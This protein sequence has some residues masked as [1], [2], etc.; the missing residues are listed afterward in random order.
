MDTIQRLQKENR[1]L[2]E[3]QLEDIKEAEES[4]QLITALQQRLQAERTHQVHHPRP[5]VGGSIFAKDTMHDWKLSPA[6]KDSDISHMESSYVQAQFTERVKIS[7]QK[8]DD[9]SKLPARTAHEEGTLEGVLSDLDQLEMSYTQI[10]LPDVDKRSRKYFDK[11][12]YNYMDTSSLEHG[13]GNFRIVD[14]V[15]CNNFKKGKN[16]RTL[17]YKTY[18]T[19][20]YDSLPSRESEFEY[21]PCREV[22]DHPT[23]RWKDVENRANH[24]DVTDESWVHSTAPGS[25]AIS[26]RIDVLDQPPPSTIRKARSDSEAHGYLAALYRELDAFK[27]RG[28]TEVP[29]NLDIHNIP[30]ELILQ[31]MPLFS[32]KYEGMNFSKF[33][34]RMV[35]LGN[36]WKNEHGIDTFSDMV[37]MDTLKILLAMAASADWEIYKVDVVEAFLTTQVNKRYPSHISKHKHEDMSYF[38]RRPPGLTDEEMPYIMKPTCYIYGHPLAMIFFNM[39]VKQMFIDGLEFSQSHYDKRVYYKH[40][41]R[42][43]VIIAHAVDDFTIFASS[44]TLKTWIISEISTRYPDVTIQHELETVLGIEVSRD[45]NNRTITLKQEGSIHNC[46]NYHLPDWKTIPLDELPNSVLSPIP[47]HMSKEDTLLNATVLPD[48]DRALYQRK[49]G[50]LVWITHTLPELMFAYKLKARKNTKPTA[51]DMKHVDYIIRYLAKI[52]RNDDVKLVL[53]GKQGI[54]MVGTVDTSYAPDGE[55]YKSIT[56][57]TIHMA[58]NTGSILTMCSR[59]TICA[60]SSMSAEGIGCHLLVR[61]IIPIRYFFKELGFPQQHPTMIYMDN[62]PFINSIVGDKGASVKSK[63]IMIRLSLI[64]E[65]YDN[66]DIDFHYMKTSDIPSDMLSKLVPASTHQHLRKFINGQMPLV[67]DSTISYSKE[68]KENTTDHF[69]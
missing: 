25:K 2:R 35:V 23:T 41:E 19:D 61:R 15:R 34:C 28:A 10:R 3:A 14:I 43:T 27:R 33:K 54:T 21:I 66:G 51:L 36:K 8:K 13:G 40:D 50:E 58:S 64:N 69:L 4:T 53:G 22:Y 26:N 46:L 60:D 44:H 32:K 30:P 29:E 18:D 38:T 17:F 16:S 7:R 55:N 9:R 12:G 63:H 31:L 49:I 48:K 5:S 37:H 45:R 67:T 59:H 1:A 47:P 52:Q 11:I 24:T 6:S 62:M 20:I 65:A 68:K 56:G 42:G 39:D 57:A